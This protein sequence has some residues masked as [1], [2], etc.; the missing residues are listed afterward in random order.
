MDDMLL[1]WLLRH[2]LQL[3]LSQ[4]TKSKISHEFC[5]S[6]SIQHSE[7]Y[8]RYKEAI[9]HCTLKIEKII[10]I[11]Q[12]LGNDKVIPLASIDRNDNLVLLIRWCEKETNPEIITERANLLNGIIPLQ[13]TPVPTEMFKYSSINQ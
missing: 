9:D 6:R 10:S 4:I 1:K 7:N 13:I 5:M 12:L 11:L 3:E 2:S 8:K